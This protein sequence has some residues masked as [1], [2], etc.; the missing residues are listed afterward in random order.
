VAPK[1]GRSRDISV[2]FGQVIT[3]S[4]ETMKLIKSLP[5]LKLP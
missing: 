4:V 5:D 2:H 1:S 3:V